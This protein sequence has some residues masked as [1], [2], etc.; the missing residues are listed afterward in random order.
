M[1]E[2]YVSKDVCDARIERIEEGMRS[3]QTG[4]NNVTTAVDK[5]VE[6]QNTR[7]SQNDIRIRQN[8]VAIVEIK[9]REQNGDYFRGEIRKKTTLWVSIGMFAGTVLVVFVPKI[10]DFLMK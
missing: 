4:Q 3:I 8:E 2:A 6:A 5:L 10:L 9:Q 1:P 7:I